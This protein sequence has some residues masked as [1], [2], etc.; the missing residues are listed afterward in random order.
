MVQRPLNYSDTTIFDFLI[1]PKV[2]KYWKNIYILLRTFL[3]PMGHYCSKK[4]YNLKSTLYSEGT[5]IIEGTMF[6]RPLLITKG[7]YTE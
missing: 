1:S 3:I 5:Y 6:L 2:E 4:Y 7:H